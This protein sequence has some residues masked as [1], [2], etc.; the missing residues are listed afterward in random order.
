M[1]SIEAARAF[2]SGRQMGGA[3]SEA[4]PSPPV[5]PPPAP[6]AESAVMA[7]LFDGDYCGFD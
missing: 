2:E 7:S 5:S 6:P 4:T 1:I 3:G